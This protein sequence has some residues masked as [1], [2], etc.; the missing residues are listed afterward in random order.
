MKVLFDVQEMKVG[1]VL[2]QAV[3]GGDRNICVD[4]DTQYWF[5]H[6]TPNMKLYEVTPEQR[7]MLIEKVKAHHAK[8]ASH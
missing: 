4:L 2:L 7:K 6:P 1:C 3:Y 8:M 5:L